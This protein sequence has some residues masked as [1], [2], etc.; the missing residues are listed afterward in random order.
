MLLISLLSLSLAATPA[1]KPKGVTQ[2][3]A[4]EGFTEYRLPNGFKVLLAPD[5]SAAQVTVN[6]T[7]FVG[8]RHEDYGEKGMA[9]LFEHMLFKRTKKIASIKKTL[10]EMG[11]DA[12][13]STWFDRT[14]YME[15]FPAKDETVKAAI[16]LE[17]ERLVNAIISREELTTEMTVVRNEFEMGENNPSGVLSE[18]VISAAFQWHNYGNNTIGARSDIESVPTERLQ[19]FYE[20]YYQPDNAMLVVA[21]KFDDAKALQ[22]AAD[23]FGKIARPKRT[24][25]QTYTVE[26]VQDGERQVTVRRVGGT[27]VFDVAYHVPASSDPEFAAVD[28][29]AAAL[30]ASPSGRLY[31]GLVENKKAAK[32]EC[33][34]Y[35]MR[36][37]GVLECTVEL[38]A[39]DTPATARDGLLAELEGLEKKPLTAA[40]VERAKA[41]IVKHY[42]VALNSP[43]RVGIELSEFAGVG[44]WRL[45][46]IHRD[47][48]KAVTVD[49][50]NRVAQ[51]YLKSSNRTLG[52]YVPTEKPDRAAMPA[53]VDLGPVIKAYQPAQALVQG[54]QFEATPANIEA[55]TTRTT[56]GNGLKVAMLSKRTR[57]AT[58][59]LAR[60]RVHRPNAAAGH[61]DQDA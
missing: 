31:K 43:D 61:Q 23:A 10:S 9:H 44:D 26:P 8:S 42:E 1:P 4:V 37:P 45:F 35:M 57:G 16:E 20:K 30:G 29:L 11:G 3:A 58:V 53:V 46:F 15:T 59:Q 19:A 56:L 22:W 7:V 49:D 38:T 2:E 14:N 34:T 48:V 18:R 51:K 6:L 55:R 28:V 17:A 5:P 54:E 60:H 52:E 24:A 40:E 32:T 41:A 25:P 47:R 39:K 33:T 21:G 12:N 13:G 27:P 50:V 36:E